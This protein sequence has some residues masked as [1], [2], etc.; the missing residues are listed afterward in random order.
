MF[1]QKRK[2]ESGSGINCF[3]NRGWNTSNHP[4]GKGGREKVLDKITGRKLE[5][6]QTYKQDRLLSQGSENDQRKKACFAISRDSKNKGEVKGL[7]RGADWWGLKTDGEPAYIN[8]G[9]QVE[10]T[11]CRAREGTSKAE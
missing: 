7:R 10:E 6:Y 8:R 1:H 5:S 11:L 9:T 3:R 2:E 4:T